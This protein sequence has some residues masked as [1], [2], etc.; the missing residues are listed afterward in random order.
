MVV[1][2]GGL[3]LVWTTLSFSLKIPRVQKGAGLP[4]PLPSSLGGGVSQR[5]LGWQGVYPLF[6]QG[7]RGRGLLAATSAPSGRGGTPTSTASSTCAPPAL[8][9]RVAADGRPRF[10]GLVLC[11]FHCFKMLSN[12]RF[13]PMLIYLSLH[14]FFHL[15]FLSLYFPLTL[16]LSVDPS[17][18]EKAMSP[19]T[20]FAAG[21]GQR[22]AKPLP[23]CG[24][25]G[26]RPRPAIR[27]GTLSEPRKNAP[28]FYLLNFNQYPEFRILSKAISHIFR[29]FYIFKIDFF[30][31][32]VYGWLR[33]KNSS[34]VP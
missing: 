5:L 14:L 16:C 4:P 23:G 25:K 33:L 10:E 31:S 6:H 13:S 19:Q 20:P 34:F 1:V 11:N 32:E 9:W 8:G 28:S 21:V 22:G 17:S 12:I 26:R 30:V 18:I 15:S 29:S 24:R 2:G 7:R 27:R 3:R